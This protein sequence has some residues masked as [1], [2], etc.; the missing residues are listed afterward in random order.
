[1]SSLITVPLFESCMYMLAIYGVYILFSILKFADIS[2]DNVFAFGSIS[3][4]YILLNTHNLFL[5][6]VFV[7]TFGFFI[8]SFTSLLFT[9]IKVPKLL[10]GIITYSILFSINIKFFHKPNVSFEKNLFDP[11]FIPYLIIG[12]DLFIFIF[13]VFLFITKIGKSLVTAGNNPSILM[14]FGAPYKFLLLVGV[15]LCNAFIASSG[16]LTSLYFGFSDVN[17]GVGI[18]INSVAAVIISERIMS[19]FNKKLRFLVVFIGILLY[20]FLLYFI[21][22]YLSFGFLDFSDYKLISGFIIIMFFIFNR[23]QTRDIISI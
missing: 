5:A 4:A 1:M 9:V 2:T 18:L 20:N 8:G 23:N 13:V 16:F 3:G 12:L 11:N 21:I 6:I 10:A 7:F 14:E 17:I 19:Y 15:G 22:S